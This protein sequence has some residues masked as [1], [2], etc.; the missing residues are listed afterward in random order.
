MIPVKTLRNCALAA[1]S[2]AALAL[3][4]QAA[5]G[6]ARHGPAHGG[7]VILYADAGFSGAG[8]EIDGA[9]PD[10]AR[11]RFND[12]VSSIAMRSGA[13]EVC[14][15]ANFRGRCRIIDTSVS[16]LSALRLNDNISSLRPAGYGAGAPRGD[17]GGSGRG[18]RADVVLF[19]DSG[20]RGQ[21]IEV[22]RDIPDLSD[23]RFNDR[24][25]SI[26]VNSGTWLACE[27]ANYRGRCEVVGRGSGEL[28]PIG[29]NDNISSIRRYDSRYEARNDRDRYGR[30]D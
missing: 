29:L 7:G 13:W 10:L 18:N 25:S 1:A 8:L 17:W 2:L 19:A 24:A 3:P 21:P 9:V 28:R 30:R 6:H 12:K 5:P 27:H 26:L 23:Y 20:L 15:D 14:T 11:L 4:A 22:N 16:R